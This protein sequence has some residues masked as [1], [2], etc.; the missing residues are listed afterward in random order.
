MKKQE[1]WEKKIMKS[2]GMNINLIKLRP[3]QWIPMH[4]HK[5]EKYNY[6]L[7]GSIGFG[8]KIWRKGDF[9]VNKKGS[10]HSLK[11]GRS[12]CEF[13]VISR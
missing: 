5:S 2:R 6:I 9:V 8:K 7:K 3:G 12:G 10:S 1:I 11:A 4:K 13:L